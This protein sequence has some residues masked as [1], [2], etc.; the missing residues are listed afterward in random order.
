[1]LKRAL[2][3]LGW[4]GVALV[5]AAVAISQ[6]RPE[7]QWY[8]QLAIGG[9]V[10]TLLY[11]LSQWREI[12]REFSGRQARFGTLATASILVVLGI[13]AAI[14]YL[15]ARNNKRWDLTAGG[16]YTLSD[17]T[18][19]V[20]HSL[21][22]PVRV[23]V[24]A[25]EG[26]SERFRNRLDQYQYET[27]QLQ[28]EYIDPEKRPALAERLKEAAIGT[29]VFEYD[30]RVQRV[31]SDEEQDLTNAL[32]KVVQGE[33]HKVY[34]IQGHGERDLN[35]SDGRGY[36]GVKQA[37]GGD[38]FTAEPLV[39]LQQE[40]PADATLLVLAGP[41]SDL[42]QPEVDR[43]RS[44]L[45]RGGKLLVLLDP[46]QKADAPPLTNV[47]ALLKEWSV[48]PGNDAVLDPLSRLRG[49]EADVPV[50]APPYPYH[51]ITSTF[52]MLTAY[53]FARSMKAA[54]N[55]TAGHQVTSFVQSG[56]GSW[57]ETDLKTLTTRGEA[58][59]NLENGD[60]RGPVSLAVAVSA[61]VKDA[62]P[63]APAPGS[64]APAKT[65]ETR[66][67]ALGDSDFAANAF[68]N[69]GG[70][71]DMFLNTVNWLAQ[72]ENLIAVRPR[73]PEDRRI[74]VGTPQQQRLIFW[75]TVLIM[76]GLIL[77]AGVHAWWRRR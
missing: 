31:S 34:F 44:Y 73:D 54:E 55:I 2:G 7:W 33:Q 11:V 72:Q 16:Q 20:L 29:V 25:R 18:K 32:I 58:Q 67:V 4:L 77:L 38:N 59:P 47:L 69:T 46:P 6:L 74:T 71:R 60:T 62:A 24:F 49:A 65:P 68:L 51:E 23:T 8:R 40:I 22:K 50:A 42:L 41:M 21:E 35:A 37:L 61:P 30:G 14:N 19:K 52:R 39:L 27:K 3:L 56:P 45:N 63:P 13:L 10:C 64:D 70:N 48:N 12:A 57:A 53:P 76:P 36:A 9:L 5:L 75:F 28:I 43:L 66:L 1:M 26:E 15:A 17:Q